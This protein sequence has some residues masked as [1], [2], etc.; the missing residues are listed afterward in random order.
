MT[1]NMLFLPLPA[2]LLMIQNHKDRKIIILA[3]ILLNTFLFI[4]LKSIKREN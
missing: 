4:N 3:G 2:I 1:K